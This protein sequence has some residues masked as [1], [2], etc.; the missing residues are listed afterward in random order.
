MTKSEQNQFQ[1]NFTM[2][3]INTGTSFGRVADPYLA[4]A[5]KAL[6]PDVKI[7]DRKTMAGIL[8]DS[9]YVKVKAA[10]DAWLSMQSSILT[11]QSDGW[12]NVSSNSVVNY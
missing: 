1:E 2:H 11:L 12:S 5:L 6:R 8:L 9:N 10:V 7:P 3:Y 4:K